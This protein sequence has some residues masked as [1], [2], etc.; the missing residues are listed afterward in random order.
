M[1]MRELETGQ[2]M[3]TLRLTKRQAEVEDT[4]RVEKVRLARA[5]R[6]PFGMSTPKLTSSCRT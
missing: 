5:L 6:G 1:T 4:A 3:L 2:G